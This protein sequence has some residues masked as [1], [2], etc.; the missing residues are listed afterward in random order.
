MKQSG[1][2]WQ[3][4]EDVFKASFI[5]PE[6]FSRS[7]RKLKCWSKLQAIRTPGPVL[8]H[9][10]LKVAMTLSLAQS[11]LFCQLEGELLCFPAP[12]PW[13]NQG[14]QE[15]YATFS[16]SK[17]MPGWPEGSTGGDHMSCSKASPKQIKVFLSASLVLV[18]L[19]LCTHG[20]C[21][22]VHPMTENKSS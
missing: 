21:P 6:L 5:F 4:L 20:K 13:L 1:R 19:C 3:V 12:C 14:T 8:N 22:L 16:I 17:W 10:H 2:E 9:S 7:R 18:S 11:T 15:A